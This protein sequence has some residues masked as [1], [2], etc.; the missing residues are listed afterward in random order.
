LPR[1]GEPGKR[2][3]VRRH[4]SR[5]RPTWI[6]GG[7]HETRTASDH[8]TVED[9][10]MASEIEQL[11]DLAGYLKIASQ[12]HWQNVRLVLPEGAQ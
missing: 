11:P 6:G 12:A 2:E 7:V 5:S 9:A 3:V 1:S 10:V 8:H 4:T